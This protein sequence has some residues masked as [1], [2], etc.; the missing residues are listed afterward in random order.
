MICAASIAVRH[1]GAKPNDQDQGPRHRFDTTRETRVASTMQL[2]TQKR[3]LSLELLRS[4]TQAC[5][6]VRATSRLC[7]VE[8]ITLP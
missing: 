1:M 4:H 8:H 7:M 6:T 2:Q 3:T 5:R